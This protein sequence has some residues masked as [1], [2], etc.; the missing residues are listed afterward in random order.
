MFDAEPK[1]DPVKDRR[2]VAKKNAI[3][4]RAQNPLFIPKTSVAIRRGALAN[5]QRYHC[6][7]ATTT[8]K[9]T[10]RDAEGTRQE[11]VWKEHQQD[12]LRPSVLVPKFGLRSTLTNLPDL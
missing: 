10:C 7:R 1:A 12:E 8:I 3:T 6:D 5:N 2:P 11:H 4:K 9:G